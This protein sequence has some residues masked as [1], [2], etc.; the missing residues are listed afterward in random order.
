[1]GQLALE[2]L[3]EEVYEAKDATGIS[4]ETWARLSGILD[5]LE[6]ISYSKT[7]QFQIVQ[8]AIQKAINEPLG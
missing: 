5:V 2:K 4:R 7:E 1:M 6:A 3:I 8:K